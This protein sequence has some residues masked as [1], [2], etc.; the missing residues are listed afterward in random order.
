MA[1]VLLLVT[2]I[3]VAIIDPLAAKQASSGPPV[4]GAQTAL[5]TVQRRSLTAQQT[6]TGT[7]GYSGVWT[8][9]VPS[10]TSAETL[11]QAEQQAATAQAAYSTAQVSLSGDKQTLATAEAVFQAA[12]LKETSDC[13]GSNAAAPATSAGNNG[14]SAAGASA[15]SP[16]GLSPCA[17]SMQAAEADQEALATARQTVL[18][19]Q[20]QL[21]AARATLASAHGA[22]DAARSG[23]SD[24]GSA[25]TYTM[26]PAPGDVIRRGQALYSINGAGTVLLYGTTPAWRSLASGVSPGPDVAQLNA[27]LDVLGFGS[28]RGDSFTG[29]TERAVEA[30]QRARGLRVTG[31]LPLGSV[32]FEPS[33]ARVVAVTPTVGQSVQ[34]G[35]IMT[36]SSTRHE[37][38][39][40]LDVSQQSQVNERDRV[41]VTL[42]NNSTTPGVVASV[43]KVAT[44]PIGRPGQQRKRRARLTVD[45][46]HRAAPASSRRGD[47]RPGTG[48]RT[49]HDRHRQE[50][51][52]CPGECAGRARGRRLRAR[53]SDRERDTPAD[54][55]HAWTVRRS[56]GVGA[57][58]RQRRRRWAT[59]R[60]ACVMTAEP[61][62]LLLPAGPSASVPV[63]ELDAVTMSYG[64]DAPVLA[65]RGVSFSVTAGELV[66]IV[67]PSGSGKST[68]LHL[69]GTLERPTS[70]R[71]AVSGHDIAELSDRE[72]AALRASQIGF[73]FQQ[74][75]L[76]EHSTLLENVADG[77]LYA[78]VPAGVRRAEAT[79]ALDAVGLADRT[80]AR[81]NQ[82]SGGERQRVAIARALVGQPAIVLAD[83]PTGNLD[84]ATGNQ[85]MDLIEHLHSQ[86][87]TIVV[88]THEHAIAERCPRH[89][90][91][92]DGRIVA[93]TGTRETADGER[94]PVK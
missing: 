45:R 12:R 1:A 24:Y 39:I 21:T 80:G 68:L 93:D 19:D 71:V 26:L 88:I 73:V 63:L 15:A 32:V 78:G 89:I 6:V 20:G 36:L 61:T 85:I 2:G 33:A 75:F 83:E 5:Q 76:A 40:E 7:L 49:D 56:G 60:G 27:N 31:S 90:Q 82:L 9:A 47:A 53:R 44:V 3:A 11:Q 92:L 43:G 51:S 48:Q 59:G 18:T 41:L 29:S 23:S 77:L 87:T 86:G 64:A 62:G 84:S 28:S 91:I 30:L 67:G 13:A 94:R 54:P 66:A 58:Q 4:N 22:L 17:S 42:P 46:R 52:R 38:S 16:L 8:V 34:A 10:T 37:V 25:A 74:F 50:R 57:S 65:L 79:N 69:M 14:G 81:P 70:G 72:L 35:S 55:G